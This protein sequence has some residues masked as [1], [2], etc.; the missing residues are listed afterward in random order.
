M[1]SLRLYRA[2]PLFAVCLLALALVDACPAVAPVSAKSARDESIFVSLLIQKRELYVGESVPVV[3]QVGAG[4][5]VVASLDSPPTLRGDGFTLNVLSGEPEREQRVV[6]GKPCTL[7][8]WHSLL[9]AVKPGSLSLIVE[10]PLTVRVPVA[11]PPQRNYVD[12]STGDPYSDPAFQ[13]L[14]QSTVPQAVVASSDTMTFDVL[15]LPSE[16]RPVTFGGAV[17]NFTI[18]SELSGDR[19]S[20]G[21]PVKLRMHVVGAGNFDRVS[22]DM[23]GSTEGWKVYRPTA[24]FAPAEATGYRG[25]KIFEQP[26]VATRP[27]SA[28]LPRLAF[29][30]FNP[31]TRHYETTYAAPLEVDVKSGPT[32]AASLSSAA[33]ATDMESAPHRDTMAALVRADRRTSGATARSL[34]PLYLQ[35]RFVGAPLLVLLALT[36]AWFRVRRD[37]ASAGLPEPQVESENFLL[38][39]DHAA[40]AGDTQLFFRSASRA[41][42]G[43]GASHQNAE[44][45]EFLKLADEA[46]YAGQTLSSADLQRCKQIVL[47]SI[48]HST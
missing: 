35:P 18:R 41:L 13:S 43:A 22:S 7:L 46:Q 29:S 25:E 39:M 10:A 23:L 4:D 34:I 3:I 20:V 21:E 6:D 17:G 42:I 31:D 32:A 11:Q 12:E 14:L 30:F 38:Q 37:R 24:S 44:I 48:T 27:G 9:A 47:R 45:R 36:G 2:P 33:S 1:K 28:Q 8:S 19:I 40:A 16:S 26:V 5:D 15:P